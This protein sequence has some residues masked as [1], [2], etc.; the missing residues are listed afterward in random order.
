LDSLS[1]FVGGI[2][3]HADAELNFETQFLAGAIAGGSNSLQGGELGLDEAR[4]SPLELIFGGAALSADDDTSG[5][6]PFVVQLIVIACPHFVW[7]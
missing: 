3:G 4:R 5:N 1:L 7:D 6:A 2:A